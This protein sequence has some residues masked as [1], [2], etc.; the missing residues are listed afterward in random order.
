MPACV[1]IAVHLEGR[2]CS[3]VAPSSWASVQRVLQ[4]SDFASHD[5]HS[6]PRH[7]QHHRFRPWRTPP[8]VVRTCK[9]TLAQPL[10]AGSPPWAS[11][12]AASSVETPQTALRR[13]HSRRWGCLAATTFDT[14][15]KSA[16]ITHRHR[17]PLVGITAWHW[18]QSHAA[19]WPRPAWR[20]RR[21]AGRW[22]V[23]E[24]SSIYLRAGQQL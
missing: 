8:L 20:L 4:T 17:A 14:S 15:K 11:A 16:A 5:S 6:Q 2:G 23:V 1:A 3:S 7:R 10:L 13:A 9:Y 12:S 19:A 24:I 21:P 18:H 22:S